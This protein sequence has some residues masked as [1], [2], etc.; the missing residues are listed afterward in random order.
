MMT[1]QKLNVFLYRPTEI[2]VVYSCARVL[3]ASLP[4]LFGR[5]AK[6]VRCFA[7]ARFSKTKPKLHIRVTS[8]IHRSFRKS[9][10]AGGSITNDCRMAFVLEAADRYVRLP[11]QLNSRCGLFLTPRSLPGPNES[12]LSVQVHQARRTFCIAKQIWYYL[13]EL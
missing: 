8:S 2:V 13:S 9:V 6:H 12:F 7:E 5:V 1:R 4:F 10:P 11:H 3:S